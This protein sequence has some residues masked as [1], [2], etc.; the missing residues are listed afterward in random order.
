MGMF[1]PVYRPPDASMAAAE[2]EPEG[3]LAALRAEVERLR[4]ALAEAQADSGTKGKKA[5][6]P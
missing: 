4:T 6:K 3:E 1:A 2:P 5:D